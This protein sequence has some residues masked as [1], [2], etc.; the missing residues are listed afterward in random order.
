MVSI[1]IPIYNQHDMTQECI[2]A[3]LDDPGIGDYEI[4]LIDNGSF[5]IITP[6][7]SG[8]VDITVIRNEENRGFPIA[9]NQG[10]RAAKGDSIL[11]LNNDVITPM[12]AIN[13]LVAW[14]DEFSI[15]GPLTN[16]CAGR[17]QITL[18]NYRTKEEM[19][20]EAVSLLS[21]NKNVAEE[22][23]WVIGFC[24][25]FKKS[26]YEEIGEFD[27]SLWPCSGEELEFCMEA[28]SR[29]H[30]VGIAYD[31]YVHH[32]GSQTFKDL[33]GTGQV[34]YQEICTRNY[35]H[36]AKKWGADFWDNQLCIMETE[37]AGS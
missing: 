7:F 37:D 33:E 24:M 20:K 1:I 26:L 6:P 2:A 10:I 27:E 14:L 34:D 12:G 22:V 4:I 3:I 36:L 23:N 5:P 17:Q 31:V 19:D 8:F 32:F 15:V 21:E 16:Y 9:V 30:L 28:K 29:G 13:R 18:P 11:L 35:K 25:A